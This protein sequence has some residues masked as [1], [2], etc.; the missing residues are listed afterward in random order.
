MPSAYLD[1]QKLTALC[2]QTII[3]AANAAEMNDFE[4]QKKLAVIL[5][6]K[7]I[8]HL[9]SGQGP[10]ANS[11]RRQYTNDDH[12]AADRPK[13]YTEFLDQQAKNHTY[14]TDIELQALAEL[15]E[16]HDLPFSIKVI[17]INSE[18]NEQ[19]TANEFYK[20]KNTDAPVIHLTCKD[21]NHW[22]YN[23]HTFGDGN[24]LYNAIAQFVQASVKAQMQPA[25]KKSVDIKTESAQKIVLTKEQAK[26]NDLANETIEK[27]SNQSDEQK[28][29]QWDTFVKIAEQ[30][31]MFGGKK[32]ANAASCASEV[33]HSEPVR[34][35]VEAVR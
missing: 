9:R 32:N 24:C 19:H 27:I 34:H 15:A 16:Q 8:A 21:N 3:D 12:K 14:A 5:R 11:F 29:I 31:G 22:S 10:V 30:H 1:L 17:I 20:A 6:A 28:A 18:K 23:K 33:N 4:F 7:T 2:G 26:W 13:T 35:I 25:A